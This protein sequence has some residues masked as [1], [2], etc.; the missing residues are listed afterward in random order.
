[1]PLVQPSLPLIVPG[2]LASPSPSPSPAAGV[3]PVPLILGR[4]GSIV[5]ENG[6]RLIVVDPEHPDPS[7]ILVGSTD[8]REARWSPDMQSV[9][10]VGGSGP[11]AELRLVPAAGGSLRRLT[12]N[13]RPE[14]GA[15]WSPRG[16]RIAYSLPG[17]LG[18]D[19]RDDPAAPAELWL[20]DVA[21][22]TDRKL[23]DGFDPAWSPDGRWIAYATNGQRDEHGPRN[24]ALRV[25]SPDGQDDRP[26]L[27]I[28]DVPPDLLPSAG[29]PFKPQTVRLRAPEWSP[30]GQRLVASADG[31]TSMAVTFDPQGRISGAWALAYEG[32]IGRARWS[33]DAARLAVESQP[34]TGVDVVVI[35]D[36]GSRRE[37]R[38]GGPTAGFQASAPTWA[39]DGRRVAL[40]ASSV[41]ARRGDPR[42]TSLR[43]FGTDG[44]EIGRLTTEADL[45][46]PDW[47]RAP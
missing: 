33:P 22:G 3:S 20:L 5:V 30:D 18:P 2:R 9:L 28:G 6:G 19:G 14:R 16:D 45:R 36:L 1:L 4:P 27:E 34:A 8:N 32:G 38:I 42:E 46:G 21:T 24:N 26:L 37:V 29:L 44:R 35:V 15:A 13:G 17:G 31:H 11:G 12:S 41:P 25:I 23:A 7:R 40:I 47:G 10:L 39:P 43:L